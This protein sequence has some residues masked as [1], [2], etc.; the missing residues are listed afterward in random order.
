MYHDL[1]PTVAMFGMKSSGWWFGTVEFYDFPYIWNVIIPTD[2]LHHFSEGLAATTNQSSNSIVAGRPAS[3]LHRPS[4]H[5]RDR[6]SDGN[7]MAFL[8]EVS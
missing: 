6:G 3:H 1:P 8:L 5:D 7:P 4:E 2:E